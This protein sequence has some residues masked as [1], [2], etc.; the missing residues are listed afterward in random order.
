MLPTSVRPAL[1]AMGGTMPP[2]AVLARCWLFLP[3]HPAVDF[4]LPVPH[5]QQY[6]L[7][8]HFPMPHCYAVHPS[9]ALVLPMLARAVLRRAA[10]ASPRLLRSMASQTA[11]AAAAEVTPVAAGLLT[12]PLGTQLSGLPGQAGDVLSFWYP[13]LEAG[14]EPPFQS[15]WFSSTPEDDEKMRQQFGALVATA[16]EGG[17]G[18]AACVRKC[19]QRIPQ[20]TTP[21]AWRTGKAAMRGAWRRS[22]CWTS[23]R[24]TCTV[25]QRRRS[26]ETQRCGWRSVRGVV[27]CPQVSHALHPAGTTADSQAAG[28]RSCL[29]IPQHSARVRPHV[30]AHAL[31]ARG[32][33]RDEQAA[34]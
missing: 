14:E 21:Q 10:A 9:P 18:G 4:G 28:R 8:S 24:A 33:R 29:L 20:A 25:A 16:L 6:W 12:E 31:H 2:P 17:E 3:W 34:D 27:P 30:C 13:G 23:S 7:S 19:G 11:P 22:C 1:P 15:M 5:G 26:R 32:G